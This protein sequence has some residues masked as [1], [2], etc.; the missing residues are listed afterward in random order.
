MAAALRTAMEI[1]EA[2]PWIIRA[3]PRWLSRPLLKLAISYSEYKGLPQDSLKQKG[4]NTQRST[5]RGLIPTLR[6]D[7]NLLK[8]TEGPM[9]RYSALR[10]TKVLLLSGKASRPFL[11]HSCEELERIIPN[12]EH[13]RLKGLDHLGSGNKNVGGRPDIV[14]DA[15]KNFLANGKI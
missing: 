14:A 13:V 1:T 7:F 9:E 3:T 2:G 10:G 11:I 12:V 6:H 5:F 8:E 15:M 4:E